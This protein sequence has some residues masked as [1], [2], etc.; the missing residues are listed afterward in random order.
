[1]H[2][3]EVMSEGVIGVDESANLFDAVQTMLEARV[4]AVFVFSAAGSIVGI[5]SEGDLLRRTE[6][7]SAQQRSRWLDFFLTGSK[8]AHDYAHSH[9]RKVSDVMTKFIVSVSEDAE[10]AEAIDIMTERHFKRLPV[11]RGDEVVGVIARSD[12]LRELMKA[13]SKTEAARPDAEIRTML[14]A[15]IAD[16]AWADARDVGVFVDHGVVTLDGSVSDERIRR[17]I[18]VMA[19]NTPGVTSVRNDLAWIE[20]NSGLLLNGEDERAG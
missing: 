16:H 3:K 8:A 15:Q 20:P 14:E 13:R 18:V 2:V 11:M 4:S 6:L 5:L 12:I 1:M 10:I 17:A 19:E 9:G 7:G